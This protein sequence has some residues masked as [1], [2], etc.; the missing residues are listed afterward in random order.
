VTPV[1]GRVS[2]AGVW[3]NRKPVW[4]LAALLLSL[5]AGLAM[6][7]Y[8]YEATWT[9]LQRLYLAAYVRSGLAAA[10][11][12][13]K[14]SRYDMLVIATRQGGGFAFDDTNVAPGT[15]R[16]GQPTWQLTDRAMR[17]GALGLR[18]DSG[19]YDHAKL[20]AALRHWVY[21]D[22]DPIDFLVTP[23]ASTLIV[24]VLALAVAIPKDSARARARR[25]GRRL[26]GPEL[27]TVREFNRRTQATGLGWRQAPTLV[28]RVLGRKTVLR[29][30]HD[31]EYSHILVAGDS[32]TGKSLLIRQLLHEVAARG[33]TA[34]VYDPALDYAPQFYQRDRGDV[35]LN[36]LDAR[37]PYWSPADE[38]RHDAEALTIAES[39]FP[40]EPYDT[41]KFFTRAPRRIFAHLLKLGPSAQDL[42]VWLR[43]EAELDRLLAGTPYAA[44]VKAKAPPQRTGVISSLNMVADALELLPTEIQGSGRWSATGWSRDR[45]GWLFLTSTPETRPSLKPLFSLWFDLLVLRLMNQGRPGVRPVWFVIDELASLQRLPQLHTAITEN[46][47]SHNPVVLGF[48]SRSQLQVLYGRQAETMLSQ[49]ATKFFFRVSEAD[50]AEW[51]SRTIGNIETERLAES[52]S[53]G[54]AR[55]KSWGLE[56]RIEP[57]VM[58]SEISGLPDLHGYMKHGNLVVRVR[59]PYSKPVH[60][61]PEFVERPHRPLRFAPKWPLKEEPLL[62]PPPNPA[63]HPDATTAADDAEDDDAH[64]DLFG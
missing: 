7:D 59:V 57:L 64:L 3:P 52:R 37:S 47:K 36:P 11:G 50:A 18:W 39:L 35:I 6:A 54:G 19:P 14:S 32:G 44:M 15:D 55:E 62:Q 13:T 31:R 58:D 8:R 17:A 49:P 63:S 34:I 61:A 4:T 48:Q 5:V 1:W 30:P 24:A 51:V 22:Q 46:R 25:H 23:V 40:D 27:L 12:I 16:A 42:A 29:I 10:A 56:R 45:Q 41:N 28:E 53:S 26:R 2:D 21:G 38:L 60:I 33:E 43:D 9:P 20:H